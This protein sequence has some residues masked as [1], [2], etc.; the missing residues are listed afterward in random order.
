MQHL[1]AFSN[2]PVLW[3]SKS[4]KLRHENKADKAARPANKL[5]KR[6]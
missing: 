5:K 4:F 1:L 6:G 3:G 2:E